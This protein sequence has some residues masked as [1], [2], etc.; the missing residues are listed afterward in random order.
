MKK[1]ILK[2]IMISGLV[3]TTLLA[4][5]L[6]SVSAKSVYEEYS[7]EALSLNVV[8]DKTYSIEE[9]LT[10]AIED[11]FMAKAEYEAIINT[12][13]EVKPFINIVKAEQIHIDLLLPLFEV[14]GV[15]I[16]E[17]TASENVVIPDSITSALATGLEAEEV[18]IAMY[19]VFLSQDNLPDNIR[20]AFEY[21]KAASEK[22]LTAFSKDRYSYLKDDVMNQ[23]QNKWQKAFKGEQK[24]NGS[25][26]GNQYREVNGQNQS[27]GSMIEGNNGTC[28][29]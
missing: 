13:G 27:Q 2:G 15:L 23:I 20:E 10:Y 16:P 19:E 3:V 25:G 26:K 21:L 29:N 18:N 8:E 24:G 9:M 1:K 11:E 22:H 14:Y 12:F 7:V 5:S 4:V 6:I 17:N 28:D